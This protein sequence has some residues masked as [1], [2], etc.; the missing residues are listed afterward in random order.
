MASPERLQKIL[1]R[2]GFGSRRAC[3]KLIL[4]GRVTVDG[5][6]VEELGVR[7]DPEKQK[8]AVDGRPVRKFES[9]V[10]Y[11]LNKPRGV[12]CSSFDPDGR[13][14]AVD[15]IPEK[16]R[17]YTVGRL[18]KDTEGL[19]LLTNDGELANLLAHPRYRVPR[20][21]LARVA[22]EADSRAVAKLRRGV[23]LSEG[24]TGPALVKVLRRG[25]NFST[26]AVSIREG[27]NRE[28]RRMLAKTGL[29][30]KRLRRIKI[31]PL[32]LGDLPVGA[33]RRLTGAEV[34]RLRKCA[35]HAPAGGRYPKPCGGAH[36]GE[37]QTGSRDEKSATP[38]AGCGHKIRNRGG[39]RPDSVR[40]REHPTWKSEN[41][42]GESQREGAQE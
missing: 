42:A 40:R 18:D 17:I 12:L 36:P 13:P 7:A 38:G 19:I 10:Y 33:F 2:A 1:A 21:Y 24:R 25:R 3:E 26:L 27:L 5:V 8:I 11:A 37:E 30:V 23:W 20:T 16:R 41:H 22:G 32:L 29:K 35:E 31:G 9:Y 34:A 15:L 4:E 28:V 39:Q 6:A 14:L